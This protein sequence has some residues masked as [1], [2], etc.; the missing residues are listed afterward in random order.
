M[1]D[2]IINPLAI[3][4]QVIGYALAGLNTIWVIPAIIIGT[5]LWVIIGIRAKMPV[6]TW[7]SIISAVVFMGPWI[8][9]NVI[10]IV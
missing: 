5:V 10:A 3:V 9:N 4:V 8:H 6:I 7:S 2:K 1:F